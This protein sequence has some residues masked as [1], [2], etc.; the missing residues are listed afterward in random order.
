MAKADFK[1]T[2][3]MI[4]VRGLPAP[5][6]TVI[7]VSAV[8]VYYFAGS[9]RNEVETE[10]VR[11]ASD[12]R[13]MIDRF[14]D[15][16]ASD[17][18]FAASSSSMAAL[19]D[20]GRLTTLLHDL[21]AGSKA[22]SDLGVF[23]E[24]GR[25]V[26]YVGPYDL[27][28][29]DYAQAEWFKAVR[30]KGLYVSNV[31]LGY[32]QAPHFIIAVRRREGEQTWYLRATVDTRS[33]NDLVRSIRMGE[34]GEAY[35]VSRTGV[36]QTARWSGGELME[37]DP[38]FSSYL[39]ADD[40]I[41]FFSARGHGGRRFLYAAGP[42]AGVDWVL[43]V[44]QEARDAYGALTRAVLIAIATI[45][46]GGTVAGFVSY[47]R[48]SALATT[49]T[50][51]DMEKQ[52][53]KTQLIIAGKLAEVGEMSAGVAHEI[54][55]PLQVMQSE[56]RLI[57]DLVDDVEKTDGRTD[58]EKYGVIR[59]SLEQ[60][61]IQIGRCS[62]IT[63]DLLSFARKTERAREPLNVQELLPEVVGM[64]ERRAGLANIDV[65]QELD[66]DLPAIIGDA[67][68]LRQVFLNLLNN[69]LYALKDREAGEIRIAVRREESGVVIS[70]ADNGCGIRTEDLEKIFVPFFTT[71]PPGQGTGLG[72]STTYGIV[73][74]CG[75]DITVTSEPGA[76]TAFIVRLPL[77]PPEPG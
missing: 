40:G 57:E 34:T 3:R 50:V 9:L 76:G 13:R 8:L 66:P 36:F 62:R 39:T 65:R 71:K 42:L 64:I 11:V 53:I 48:A 10:L 77:E 25:H 45:I 69:A 37:R 20:Q 43:V 74:N 14:L 16:R 47:L 27:A 26:A 23:D 38:D 1:A 35:L 68:Q 55:N 17:L 2:R 28:G 21:Q 29:K 44:R 12:H 73:E 75:G 52:H 46:I 33:F 72:L 24:E 67:D 60:C 18:R 32:R 61:R 31:F 30:E 56:V 58:K 70:I 54:N 7:L 4:L 51:A 15:E 6:I 19:S 5:F 63:N 59:E 22:F 41:R 49:L